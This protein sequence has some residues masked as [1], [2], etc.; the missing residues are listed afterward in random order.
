MPRPGTLG[1][2]AV[3]KAEVKRVVAYISTVTRMEVECFVCHNSRKTT[4]M[5]RTAFGEILHHE[6]WRHG[7]SPRL[8]REGLMCP[9]CFVLLDDK[10]GEV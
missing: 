7:M 1:L 5:T 9:K 2:A 3:R 4:N 8:A 6:G 10:R